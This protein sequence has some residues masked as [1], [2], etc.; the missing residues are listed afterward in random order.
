LIRD[1]FGAR[2]IFSDN[3]DH[4]SFFDS[5][6][7]SGWLDKVYEDPDCSVFHIRDQKSTPPPEDN[8]NDKDT[9]EGDNTNSP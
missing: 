1:R 9:S 2:W 3:K 5:A 4:E 6:L 8:H 7:R